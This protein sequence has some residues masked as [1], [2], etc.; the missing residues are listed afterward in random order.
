MGAGGRG[1]GLRE[2]LEQTL[3]GRW[4][5]PDSGVGDLDPQR[6]IKAVSRR[7]ARSHD[8]AA[9]ARELDRVRDDV[10]QHLA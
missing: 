1:V 9:P 2:R 6:L 10:K 3:H 4:V 7:G 8:D 5:D